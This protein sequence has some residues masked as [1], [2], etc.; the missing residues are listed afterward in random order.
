[1]DKKPKINLIRFKIVFAG[2]M[3]T[4]ALNS[5]K[6]LF[7]DFNENFDHLFWAPLF[8]VIGVLAWN[9]I[10]DTFEDSQ[11]AEVDNRHKIIN[12]N[13]RNN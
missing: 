11:K 4:A 10:E 2:F 12:N 1:M 7:E 6:L 3:G 5:V 13:G 8:I 9:R